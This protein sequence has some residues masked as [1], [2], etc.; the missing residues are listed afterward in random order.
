LFKRLFKDGAIYGLGTLLARGVNILLLPF[1]TRVLSPKDYGISDV[2]TTLVLLMGL[3]PPLEI[4]QGLTR[5]FP[6]AKSENDKTFYASTAV[7]Y[8]GAISLF[9]VLA[10]LPF[11]NQLARFLLEPGDGIFIMLALLT[12]LF[13]ALYNLAMQLLRCQ[14]LALKFSIV[15]VIFSLVS[16]LTSIYTVVVLQIGIMGVLLGNLAGYLVGGILALVFARSS[17][18]WKFS[19][20][21][22]KEMLVFSAPLVPSAVGYFSTLYINRIMLK[23][24]L[25]ITDVGLYNVAYRIVS[26]INL[27]V[28][29]FLSSITPLVYQNY[30]SRDM[31]VE[32]ARVFRIFFGVALT[33]MVALSVFAKEALYLLTTKDYYGAAT[34]VPALTLSAIFSGIYGFNYG[35]FIAKKTGLVALINIISGLINIGLNLI[36]IPSLGLLGAAWATCFA[37]LANTTVSLWFGQRY[38]PIPFPLRK[39]AASSLWALAIMVI[40]SLLTGVSWLG[41]L[42]KVILV[43][44]S[45][46]VF[47]LIGLIT[48]DEIRSFLARINARF[49]V[50]FR[51]K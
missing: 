5:F 30:E 48:Y 35:L 19:P 27:I 2:I 26:P 12:F 3:I 50:S 24:M 29:T 39:I 21:K 42:I 4:S 34:I 6:N 1:Y 23:I 22:L 10:C 31:P 51:S 33:L 17:L 43:A 46:V 8:V 25:T 40:G 11:V 45:A 15:N 32:I 28:A 41:I 14:F 16:I 18:D 13:S 47:C 49:S 20:E 38:Y 7:F 9:F 36:L 37:I 44:V